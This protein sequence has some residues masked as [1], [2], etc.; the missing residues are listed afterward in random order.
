MLSCTSTFPRVA[1]EYG[2]TWWAC[3]TSSLGG[4]A[5]DVRELGLQLDG[6]VEAAGLVHAEPDARVTRIR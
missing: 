1:L 5:I 4:L 3:S 2:Q 6:D